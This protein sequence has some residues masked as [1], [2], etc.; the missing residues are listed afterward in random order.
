[1][2]YHVIFFF[3]LYEPRQIR[4]L[5]CYMSFART[6]HMADLYTLY[7]ASPPMNGPVLGYP[8][9]LSC[10]KV[11]SFPFL[12]CPGDRTGGVPTRAWGMTNRD[13]PTNGRLV[14]RTV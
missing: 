1:M 8:A 14:D 4:A 5:N 11:P 9:R 3:R 2:S 12:S 6:Q 7:D 13:R 10:I